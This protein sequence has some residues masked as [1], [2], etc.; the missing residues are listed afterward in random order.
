VQ[1][2]PLGLD[3]NIN[4]N[5][6]NNDL[7]NVSGV[8]FSMPASSSVL[9]RLYTNTQSG[10][11]VVDLFYNDG[12]GNV[13]PLTKAGVVNST[14]SSIPGESYS[15]GT[16]TWVQGS[17]STTPANFDIGLI[18]IRPNIASTTYGVQLQP[19]S[20]IASDYALVL[21][22]LPAAKGIVQLDSSGNITA[23]LVPDNST[24]VISSNTLQ[25]P[26]GG[27]TA[28]QIA[29][30]AV[31]TTQIASAAVTG[32]KL[33]LAGPITSTT[34]G[35]F[36]TSASSYVTPTNLS[37]SITTTGRPVLLM[38]Q[39][40]TTTSSGKG[41]R[42]QC[43]G[44]SNYLLSFFRGVTNVSRLTFQSDV[45]A[46]G[47]VTDELPASAFACIDAPTAGTYTYT[48]QV[49]PNGGTCNVYLCQ[50]TAVEI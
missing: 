43:A 26:S 5:I 32:P 25:V 44:N 40:D 19:P 41:G 42:I 28:T 33:G 15:G 31:G 9:T 22:A 3:I 2:T 39:G 11:G 13:I 1:I 35:L 47:F 30:G 18:T 34:S 48:F 46:A 27:I 16:F 37:V 49:N 14:A 4:L 50:L 20:G 23:T 45:S 21:P 6:Q 36:S 8:D 38:L 10:G 24:I 12:A 7:T 17:G 29:A